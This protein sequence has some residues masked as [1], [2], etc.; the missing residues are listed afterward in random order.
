MY[1]IKYNFV[2]GAEPKENLLSNCLEVFLFFCCY[3]ELFSKW[4][5]KEWNNLLAE[6]VDLLR[7]WNLIYVCALEASSFNSYSFGPLAQFR[8]TDT[9]KRC[10]I[11][12]S[13]KISS[14]LFMSACLLCVPGSLCSSIE[15][16]WGR[17]P[18]VILPLLGP[19]NWVIYQCAVFTNLPVKISIWPKWRQSARLYDDLDNVVVMFRIESVSVSIKIKRWDDFLMIV[20]DRG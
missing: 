2:S 12:N 3:V 20:F 6:R 8:A 13:A 15:N 1:S 11:H 14:S 19:I 17:Q 16:Q 10:L 5:M 9:M 4:L 18:V 7:R